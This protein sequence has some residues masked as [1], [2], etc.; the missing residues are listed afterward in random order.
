MSIL[1]IGCDVEE[2]DRFNLDK[3]ADKTFLNRIF[4]PL[5]QAYCFSFSSP[6][7]HLAGRFCAKEAVIKAF[8][9][10]SMKIPEYH[11][12]EILNGPSGVPFVSD[13]GIFE[14]MGKTINI[15][16]SISHCASYAMA[17]A[18]VSS[19]DEAKK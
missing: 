18:T 19:R 3:D 2:V 8:S 1:G 17:V 11:H 9:Q 13:S 16:I 12:I 4:T 5:E 6:A 7:P 14:D 15:H 10:A